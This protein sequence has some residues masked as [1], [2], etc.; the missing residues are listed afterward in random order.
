MI[1]HR[2]TLKAESENR[3]TGFTLESGMSYALPD[4]SIR[5]CDSQNSVRPFDLLTG[6]S[7]GA[8]WL[9]LPIRARKEAY[10]VRT[11]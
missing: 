9:T 4:S 11:R 1:Y 10:V 3:G 5:S 8:D 2:S 6:F 7:P